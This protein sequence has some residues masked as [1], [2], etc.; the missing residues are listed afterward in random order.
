[1]PALTGSNQEYVDTILP[2]YKW[3]LAICLGI[4]AATVVGAEVAENLNSIS[5]ETATGIES[6]VAIVAGVFVGQAALN[7]GL[8]S[9]YSRTGNN[10]AVERHERN[11]MEDAH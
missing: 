5:P 10:R 11:L 4:I 2:G 3:Q 6:V 8:L 7:W 9:H 1:M